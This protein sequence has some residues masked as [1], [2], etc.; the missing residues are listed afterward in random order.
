MEEAEEMKTHR[1]SSP[2]VVII[3]NRCGIL[4]PMEPHSRAAC[5]LTYGHRGTHWNPQAPPCTICG[6]D[7]IDPVHGWTQSTE[8]L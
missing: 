1:Y 5:L 3:N 2:E 7:P 8:P 4:D 6:K